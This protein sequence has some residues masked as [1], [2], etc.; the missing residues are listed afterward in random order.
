MGRG[1][2][3]LG[4]PNASPM[5]DRHGK[6]RYRFR[7]V[8]LPS[9]Y[10]PGLPG[11]PEFAAA[12]EAAAAG[13]KPLVIGQG[14]VKPGSINALAVLGYSTAEW[15]ALAPTTQ[16][17]YRGVMERL[18]RD[19]GDR[20]VA[21]L[22]RD[23]IYSLR[24]RIPGPAA[25]NNFIKAIRWFLNVAVDR[26]MLRENP[27]L[28]VKKVKYQSTGYH[29]WT[30]AEV[31]KFEARWPVGTKQRLAMDLLLFTGQRSKDVRFMGRQHLT[32]D[33]IRVK[34]SKTGA[35]LEIPLHANLAASL[36]TVPATQLQFLPTIQGPAYTAKGFGNWIKKAC[37]AAGVPECSPH[38]LRKCILT[39]LADAGCS[40]PQMMAISGHKNAKE[41]EPYIKARDQRRLAASA[42]ARVGTEE[43]RQLSNLTNRLAK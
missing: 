38:G 1:L 24:D 40:E 8:G 9:V 41:L 31:A 3:P 29:T 21:A 28:G 26:K 43:E 30:E 22:D 10:L 11:S 42:F 23:L 17:N 7:K 33:W 36:A 12:Y 13:A 34:Q 16:S 15:R 5:K 25:Q 2:K 20:I 4:F 32:G 27:S 18:R 37:I 35:E 14:R 39:R 6:V 19:Y